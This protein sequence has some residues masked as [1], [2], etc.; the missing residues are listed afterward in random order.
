[1]PG[2]ARSCG[3]VIAINYRLPVTFEP[4]FC[5]WGVHPMGDEN[6]ILSEAD[7]RHLLRRTGFE[8]KKRDLSLYTGR[9]RRFAANRITRGHGTS[10]KP[11]VR[12]NLDDSDLRREVHDLW[13]NYIMG[14]SR[15]FQE[16]MVLFWHDHFSCSNATI[17]NLVFSAN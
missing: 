10:F 6:S 4:C 5:R 3:P 17:N 11:K 13:V 1:M 15:Q 14:T 16:K 7:A 8:V 12:Y 9:T 2:C